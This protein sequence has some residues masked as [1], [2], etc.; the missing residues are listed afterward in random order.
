M[1]VLDTTVLVYALGAD[2]RLREPCREVLRH[3]T[4]LSATTTS[5]V[6]QEFAHVYARRRTRAEAVAH[7]RDYVRLLGPLLVTDEQSLHGGLDAFELSPRLGAF[8]AVL[9]A[10]A[11]RAG[12]R[13][14]VS[15][16]TAFG[17]VEGLPWVAPGSPGWAA[18]LARIG[19]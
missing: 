15:A 14:L 2:H 19:H 16:D 18:E 5:Q 12:A 6:V 11:R 7:A 1:I 10:T 8:D 9:A 3:A 17:T 4:R 13:A